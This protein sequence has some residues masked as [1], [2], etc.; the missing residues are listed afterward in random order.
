MRAFIPPWAEELVSPAPGAAIPYTPWIIGVTDPLA[1]GLADVMLSD[2]VLN[3]HWRD[4]TRAA[5][6]P[7]W[8]DEEDVNEFYEDYLPKL[9]YTCFIMAGDPGVCLLNNPKNG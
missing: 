7:G 9:G 6:H 2:E 5:G 3:R 1:P 8:E 4:F